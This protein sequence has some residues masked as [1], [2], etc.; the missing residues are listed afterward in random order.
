[1]KTGDIIQMYIE[2]AERDIKITMIVKVLTETIDSVL[3]NHPFKVL[4]NNKHIHAQS[5][6]NIGTATLNLSNELDCL[7]FPFP[8]MQFC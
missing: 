4:Q 5:R 1:M 3:R 7:N 2:H 8:N 6:R